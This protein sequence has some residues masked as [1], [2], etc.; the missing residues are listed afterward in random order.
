MYISLFSQ[1]LFLDK[2][3]ATIISSNSK[4]TVLIHPRSLELSGLFPSRTFED[5]KKIFNRQYLL[6]IYKKKN[7]K[8]EGEEEKTYNRVYQIFDE[9][10]LRSRNAHALASA[11]LNRIAHQYTY[12]QS[13]LK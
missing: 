3:R 5:T 8:E 4:T 10:I 2:S 1:T 6:S 12:R 13:P 11:R 7:G 9:M